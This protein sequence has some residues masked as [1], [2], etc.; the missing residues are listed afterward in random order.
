[1][2]SAASAPSWYSSRPAREKRDRDRERDRDRDGEKNGK[3]KDRDRDRDRDRAKEEVNRGSATETS[4][5]QGSRALIFIGKNMSN[6]LWR[7]S[8]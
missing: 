4:P 5:N 7:T 2:A 8:G 3:D 1:M 6:F